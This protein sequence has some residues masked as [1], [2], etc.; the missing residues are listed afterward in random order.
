MYPPNFDDTSASD[1]K[2]YFEKWNDEERNK[3]LFDK[4]DK[5]IKDKDI[6]AINGVTEY[7]GPPSIY[8]VYLK[9]G[10]LMGK[11]DNGEIALWIYAKSQRTK[12]NL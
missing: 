3:P 12:L 4:N 10:L 2:P 7:T 11:T 1:W 5:E 8:K 9:N 6:I